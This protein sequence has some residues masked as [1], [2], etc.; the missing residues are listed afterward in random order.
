MSKGTIPTKPEP[1]RLEQEESKLWRVVLLFLIL[2][3]AALAA[4][5]WQSLH[6]LPYELGLIP[7][8]LLVIAILF[9]V[10][11]YGRRREV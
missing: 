2:L 8:A 5:S 6:N 4:F 1:G 10:Y 9:A 11:A 7:F 3:A